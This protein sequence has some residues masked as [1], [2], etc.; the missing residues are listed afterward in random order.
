MQLARGGCDG[1]TPGRNPPRPGQ[2]PKPIS[3]H[4]KEKFTHVKPAQFPQG[5]D[6]MASLFRVSFS[7]QGPHLPRPGG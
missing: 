1:P 2:G 4:H 5:Q 7:P 6:L 3:S